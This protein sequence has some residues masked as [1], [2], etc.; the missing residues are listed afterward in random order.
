MSSSDGS[1]SNATSGLGPIDKNAVYPLP[2]FRARIGQSQHGM[3]MMRKAGLRTVKI[4][5]RVY[6]VGR[7]FFEFVEEQAA[8]KG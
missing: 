6:V 1:T 5:R 4:S 2:V 8:K 7:H 3:R